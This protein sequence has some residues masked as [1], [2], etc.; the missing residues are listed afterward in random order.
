MD[1]GKREQ[2][3]G[4]EKVQLNMKDFQGEFLSSERQGIRWQKYRQPLGLAGRLDS[5]GMWLLGPRP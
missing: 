3:S 1:L 5:T 4:Y 2:N